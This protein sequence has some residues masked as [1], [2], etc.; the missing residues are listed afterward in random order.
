MNRV[1]HA[2]AAGLALIAPGAAAH[3]NDLAG[4]RCLIDMMRMEPV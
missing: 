4:A 2:K 3:E 1:R